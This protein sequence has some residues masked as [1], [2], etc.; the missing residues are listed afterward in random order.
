MYVFDTSALSEIFRSFY[1]SRFPTL[2]KKFDRLIEKGMITSTRE[3]GRE[4]KQYGRHDLQN[5]IREHPEAFPIPSVAE[6]EFVQKIYLVRHFRQNVERKKILKGGLNA[7]PFVI[8][9][10]AAHDSLVVTLETE[11]PQ[12]VRVP[13]ICE[14]FDIPCLNLEGFMTNEDWVF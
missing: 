13:N 3:V 9:K 14:Y 8:A 12:A 7:D 6:A 1:R 10:A 2:W 5:W 11:R 4:L